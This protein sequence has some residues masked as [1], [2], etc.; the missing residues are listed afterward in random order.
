LSVISLEKV[1]GLAGNRTVKADSVPR[2][3]RQLNFGEQAAS[4]S[5]EDMMSATPNDEEE[6]FCTM[7]YIYLV[8]TTDLVKA[9]EKL[10]Q[11]GAPPP[12]GFA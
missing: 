9:Y 4:K 8:V 6:N 12:G 10:F 5:A 7:I 11:L 3:S 2:T 1:A